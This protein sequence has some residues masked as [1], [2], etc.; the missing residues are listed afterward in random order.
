MIDNMTLQQMVERQIRVRVWRAL[1]LAGLTVAAFSGL[2][3]WIVRIGLAIVTA[4]A[5]VLAQKAMRTR[6]RYQV[7]E[8]RSLA[9]HIRR[10]VN[11]PLNFH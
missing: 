2:S 3:A 8:S 10:R 9:R 11:D 4:E 7:A 6:D 5:I 1:L